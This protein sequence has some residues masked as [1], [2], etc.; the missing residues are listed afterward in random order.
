MKIRLS[1][2]VT[3][4]LLLGACSNN[5]QGNEHSGHDETHH[6]ENGHNDHGDHDHN[7]EIFGELNKTKSFDIPESTNESSSDH[8]QTLM[9]K[10]TTR[11]DSS[12]AETVSILTSQM[13]W[14][15]THGNNQPGTVILVP[16]SQWQL[17]LAAVD[18]VHHP[19]NGPVLFYQEDG[20]SDATMNEINR[21]DPKGNVNETEIMVMG[22]APRAVSEQ[23]KGYKTEE[24]K[25]SSPERFAA[26]ID[27]AY[28]EVTNGTYPENIII[29]SSEEKAKLYSL[30]AANWIAHMPEP[31]LY[32]NDGG[33]PEETKKALE[34]RDGQAN[35]YLLGSTDVLSE[36]VE[37]EL[38]DFGNVTRIKGSD[39]VT[40]SVE[41]A[42]FKDDDT[43]FGWGFDEP[44][45]GLSFISTSTSQLAIP[46][47]PFSHLGKHSPLIWLEDGEAGKIVTDFLAGI[48]PLF[49]DS[50]QDGPYNH[51]TVIGG[52]EAVSHQS[53]GILDDVLEIVPASGGEHGSH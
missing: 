53:Q 27:K 16:Q 34:K 3:L 43:G 46:A 2:M 21:L 9:T 5:D 37:K 32:V 48:K 14:P 12:D 10:N 28:A 19:N 4:V 31:L 15:A 23:L 44:G 22:D 30:I 1:M 20:I 33:I 11:L 50:P 25:A 26:E 35:L 38:K 29:V 36:K 40:M 49:K 18:L 39:P 45:H 7:D 42:S 52:R 51:G 41:F 47:A 13:I 24:M 8:L 17:G 6:A